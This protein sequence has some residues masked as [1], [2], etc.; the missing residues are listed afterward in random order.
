MAPRK[1]KKPEPK[2]DVALDRRMIAAALR[3]G[4]RNL[5]RTY[6]NPAIGALIVRDVAGAATVIGRGWTAVGGRPQAVMVALEQAGRA[7]KG[8]TAYVT[9]E[10]GGPDGEV[11]AC[12][13]ALIAAGVGRVVTTIE[14]PDQRVSGK[15]IAALEAAG[16]P[17]TLGVLA[18]EATLAHA[19]HIARIARGRPHVTLKLAVSADGM[20][21]RREGE[22]M[23]ITDKPAFDA[24]QAM[25]AESD[26]AL[27]G[28][29]TAL[30]DDPRMTVRL[31]G[32]DHR[33]PAR[34]VLD[35]TAR[36]PMNSRLVASAREFPL[37]V[38]VATGAPADRVE[39]LRES[40]A[41]IIEMPEGQGGVDMKRTL[42]EFGTRGFTRI[43]VEGGAEIASS[44]VSGDLVDEIVLFRA[45]VVVGA[46]GVRALAG[47][48]LSAIERSP[49]YR[50]IDAAIVGDD[51]MR[52]YLRT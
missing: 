25:R 40:G 10:P 51:Q 27:I 16:I 35:A 1:R 32:L 21:G 13:E 28:I 33:T 49:R 30:V 39:A 46:G 24:V 18:R 26:A 5:G 41:Q 22:R 45:P 8:A 29:G 19:G 20:I 50:Q 44:V 52:R 47:Y 2:I 12:A 38:V 3:L 15:G 11:L 31:P 37:F 36:L 4:R 17:V 48:A 9:L 34:I 7:T 43:L 23:I 14:D 6:P 42:E